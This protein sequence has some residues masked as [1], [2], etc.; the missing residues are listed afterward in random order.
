MFRQI[1]QVRTCNNFH[2]LNY[3]EACQLSINK[4]PSQDKIYLDVV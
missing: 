1:L 4:A 2:F 3:H